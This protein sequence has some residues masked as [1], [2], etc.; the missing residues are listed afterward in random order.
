[1]ST[2]FWF[3]RDLRIYGNEALI[4]AVENGARDALFFVCEQQWQQ[5][6]TAPVQ[7][8]L[9]KR[10]VVWLGHK[11]AEL[12]VRLHVLD[13]G[14]FAKVPTL[15]AQ[16][17]QTHEVKRV[18]ANREYE[19]NEQARDRTCQE[20]GVQFHL[21]DGDVIAPPGSVTTASNEMY[22]VFTPFKKAW[23]KQYEQQHFVLPGWPKLDLTPVEWEA[24]ELLT[25]D[26]SSAKWPVDDETLVKVAQAFIQDKM[27]DYKDQRDFPGVK[28]TSGL[29]PYLALGIVSVKQLLAEIQL[30][31]PELLHMTSAPAFS[32]VN[33]L[34]WREFY[35]HL[36]CAYPKLCKGFN[37]NEK[38]NEVSWRQ[39]EAQ[40]QAWC[41]G[42]TGYPI[43]DAAMRQLNQTGWMHNR[44]RMIVASFLTKHLLIDW[45]KGE[46]YF[47][48]K[49]IDGDL[50]SN[51]GGW[52]WAASTGC[53]AQPYFRIF[54]PISQSE[55]FD[56]Q[57]DFIRKFVPELS[58][59]PAKSIHFPHDYLQAFSIDGYVE[60]I[61]EHKAARE[62]A[63][64]AFK[65]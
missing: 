24:P 30:H 29:S 57:G 8:D 62:R 17:C 28:G 32:W 55:K 37:F 6:N 31:L 14:N 54:N 9:L 64:A 40:F 51:N 16:F 3:R 12:G 4:E 49:L 48:S 15:L 18:Y 52:Q 11:L 7:V 42:K 65:V 59:I 10:R 1:M 26:G 13:A 33:E 53:D 60:P 34:I 56:P 19:V 39:D 44:L 47:M 43:V 50:A 21:F 36:I 45:R 23:L 20:A 27:A 22:K 35:R 2:L 58:E 41:A 38:Y 46:Q 63:L 5:H 61:V 25:G